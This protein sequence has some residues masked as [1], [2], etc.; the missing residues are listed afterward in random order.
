MRVTAT[1]RRA[2]NVWSAAAT[3]RAGPR[4]TVDLARQA[5]TD[6]AYLGAA[7]L[8]LLGVETPGRATTRVATGPIVTTFR[9]RAGRRTATATLRQLLRSRA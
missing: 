7:S 8:G 4:G 1:T 3:F 6:H 5:P 9:A 2:E